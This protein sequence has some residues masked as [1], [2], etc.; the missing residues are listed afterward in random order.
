MVPDIIGPYDNAMAKA[1]KKRPVFSNFIEFVQYS[2]NENKGR[3]DECEEVRHELAEEA[4]RIGDLERDMKRKQET[5]DA[6]KASD[7]M[8]ADF[9]EKL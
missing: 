1:G 6:I 5:K 2:Y 4:M 9:E 7:K 3:F 8:V